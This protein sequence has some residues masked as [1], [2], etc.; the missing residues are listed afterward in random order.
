MIISAADLSSIPNFWVNSIQNLINFQQ[1]VQFGIP[2]TKSLNLLSFSPNAAVVGVQLESIFEFTDNNNNDIFEPAIDTVVRM[3]DLDRT[4]NQMYVNQSAVI[5]G[6]N[7]AVM[8]FSTSD[9]VFSFRI[10]VSDRID[11]PAPNP[12]IKVDTAVR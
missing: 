3:Y 6:A 4:W 5:G 9:G 10:E 7:V 2:Y 8:S 12:L 11:A 1:G